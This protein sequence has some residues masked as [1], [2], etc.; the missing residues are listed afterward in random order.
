MGPVTLVIQPH[1]AP[2]ER[3]GLADRL[4]NLLEA[5]R[6]SLGLPTPGPNRRDEPPA[7]EE[8]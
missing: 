2:P 6:G 8:V 7:R 1:V 4:R 3:P 5:G